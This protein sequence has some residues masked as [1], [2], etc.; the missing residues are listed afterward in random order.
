M[1]FHEFMWTFKHWADATEKFI[2]EDF[3]KTSALFEELSQDQINYL[4]SFKHTET[5]GGL[6]RAMI[7]PK[8]ESLC[9]RAF[10]IFWLF[11]AF[12]EVGG[13]ASEGSYETIGLNL[14]SNGGMFYLDLHPEEKGISYESWVAFDDELTELNKKKIKEDESLSKLEKCL[15]ILTLTPKVEKASGYISE[16]DFAFEV[17]DV[18]NAIRGQMYKFLKVVGNV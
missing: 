17:D 15:K 8:G 3:P 12:E 4:L 11:K 13:F 6:K 5:K 10:I 2:N 16:D 14:E 18:F 7:N 9:S 1:K